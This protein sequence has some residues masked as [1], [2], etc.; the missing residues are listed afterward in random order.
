MGIILMPN[1]TPG[2]GLLGE[3]KYKLEDFEGAIQSFERFMKTQ[4]HSYYWPMIAE[5]YENLGD[6][7]KACHVYSGSCETNKDS[8]SCAKLR[9]LKCSD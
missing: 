4:D 5:S 6:L 7:N 1:Y 9:K 3:I 2:H 8:K